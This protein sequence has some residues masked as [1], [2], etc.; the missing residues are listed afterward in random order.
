MAAVVI[1]VERTCQREK[2][3]LQPCE[4][5]LQPRKATKTATGLSRC[6]VRARSRSSKIN[7]LRQNKRSFLSSHQEGHRS[8]Y[9]GTTCS[10]LQD[11]RRHERHELFITAAHVCTLDRE[12]KHVRCWAGKL[13]TRRAD[14]KQSVAGVHVFLQS[15]ESNFSG[16]RLHLNKQGHQ[17][18]HVY[19]WAGQ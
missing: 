10:T 19:R 8:P 17:I 5:T 4:R 12:S 6:G 7:S 14:E 9:A 3:I 2:A 15:L 13:H 16:K 1:E 11:W 18:K